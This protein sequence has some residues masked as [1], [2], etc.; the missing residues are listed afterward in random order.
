MSCGHS[1]QHREH[2]S[3]P[4]CGGCHC[5]WCGPCEACNSYCAGCHAN[6]LTW[7]CPAEQEPTPAAEQWSAPLR[8]PGASM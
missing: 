3:D 4:P 1:L 6:V 8:T 7:W 2:S 5:G